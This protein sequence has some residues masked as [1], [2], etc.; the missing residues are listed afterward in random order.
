[1]IWRPATAHVLHETELT[2][3][4]TAHIPML[5]TG[6]GVICIECYA[7]WEVSKMLIGHRFT[8]CLWSAHHR[9]RVDQISRSF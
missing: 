2:V 1:M 5:D 8:D 7:V 4:N 9:A 6:A 3:C